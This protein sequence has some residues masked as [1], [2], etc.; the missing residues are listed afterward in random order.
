MRAA[1][2]L[3]RSRRAAPWINTTIPALLLD[4]PHPCASYPGAWRTVSNC[5][6]S[7]RAYTASAAPQHRDHVCRSRRCDAGFVHNERARLAGQRLEPVRRAALLPRKPSKAKR[8][9]GSGADSA[10]MRE[11]PGRA[12]RECRSRA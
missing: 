3:V 12:R 11:R 2:S 9:D 10:T 7:S 8:S 5:L 4:P 1:S 6:V